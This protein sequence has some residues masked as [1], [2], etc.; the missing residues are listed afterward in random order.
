MCQRDRRLTCA[1]RSD[2]MAGMRAARFWWAS[3]GVTALIVAACGART[4]LEQG[5]PA[6]PSEI[7]A[8][9]D[10]S[11]AGPDVVDA[12]ADIEEPPFDAPPLLCDDAGITFIYVVS[13]QNTLFS[14]DPPSGVFTSIGTINCPASLGATPFSMA[15]DRG[16]TAY[17]IFTDGHLFKVNTATAACKATKFVPGQEDFFT[18]GMGFSSN[19]NDPGETLF[20]ATPG[21]LPDKFEAVLASIDTNTLDLNTIGI[22]SPPIER[23]ELTG[24][25]DGRLFVFSLDN[26][27]PGSH[28]SELDKTTAKLLSSTAL[29]VGSAND[30]FAYAFWG[31]AFYF[32]NSPGGSTSTV[33]RYDPKD[34]SLVKVGTI[35]QTIVGAGVS[36]CAPH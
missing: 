22:I 31:D 15:V 34:K 20:I 8:G 14:Y 17:V 29:A 19:T 1:A 35:A 33:T 28:V 36:T 13:A 23:T 24:T 32:F 18:F 5:S 16:G 30:A 11:E 9:P 10:V 12:G 2:T 6:P 4:E 25:G 3:F 21:V 7:D 27:G 26:P